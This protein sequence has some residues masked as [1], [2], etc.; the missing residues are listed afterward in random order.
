MKINL[1]E[2]LDDTVKRHSEKKAYVDQNGFITYGQ[3]QQR[4]RAIGSNLI[5][6]TIKRPVAVLLRKSV[7]TVVCF[8]G[9]LNSGNYY[10]P[11]DVD[12]PAERIEKIIET[13]RPVK[14][15]TDYEHIEMAKA[16]LPDKD[17][18]IYEEIIKQDTDNKYLATIRTQMLDSDP[19]YILFTSGSTGIPKGVVICH[20]S[21]ID[22]IEWAAKTFCI[23]KQDRIANQT[24][25]HF[26]MAV[27]DIY[28]G[29][30]T[31]ATVFIIPKGYFT[32]PVNLIRYLNENHITTIFWVPSVLCILAKLKA[33][34]R[35]KLQTVNKILFSGEVM[36]SKQLNYWRKNHPNAIYANLYGPTEITDVC[37]YYIVDRELADDEPLPIGKACANTEILLLTDHNELAKT[38]EKG[39]I[40]VRGRS[41]ALGYFGD[42]EKSQKSFV[43]NPTN[44]YFRDLIYRTGDLAKVN[45]YGELIYLGRKDLQVK[46][47]GHRIELEDIEIAAGTVELIDGTVCIYDDKHQKI[48]LFYTG[49]KITREQVKD[50][51]SKKLPEYM[52]PAEVIY[53]EQFPYNH[54]GKID[55]KRLKGEHKSGVHS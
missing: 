14:I 13:I 34:S 26:S 47:M 23:T 4:A 35:I 3:L 28:V 25:F 42:P 16:I 11:I 17:F 29:L 49:Q 15:L 22:Y 51:L 33:F 41:L 44:P 12:M 50:H 18:V 54:N 24:P 55:R 46:H 5:D 53:L 30:K 39:E 20:A 40:C 37:S 45:A 19:A 8:L 7:Q 2:Y 31:G 9:I 38:E 36:P 6:G 27:F 21:V 10:C 32:F 52:V 48:V 43:Q 1:L